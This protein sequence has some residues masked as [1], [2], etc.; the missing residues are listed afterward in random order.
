MKGISV[1]LAISTQMEETLKVSIGV[2][3]FSIQLCDF[4]LPNQSGHSTHKQV[5]VSKSCRLFSLAQRDQCYCRIAPLH[6]KA[7]LSL[8]LINFA[9]FVNTLTFLF[10]LT[11]VE[12]RIEH[13]FPD[14]CHAEFDY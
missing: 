10:C 8:A 12:K 4:S 7:V 9:F 1:Q 11:A 5:I 14:H 6:C 3:F 13:I 2:L